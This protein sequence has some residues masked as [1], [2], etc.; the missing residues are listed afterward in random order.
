MGV[1]SF[2]A[3]VAADRRKNAFTFSA[4]YDFSCLK[5]SRNQQQQK[6]AEGKI[7]LSIAYREFNFEITSAADRF[8]AA[9]CRG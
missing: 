4:P 8:L 5:S 9:G 2:G 7:S 1:A 3:F 6:H